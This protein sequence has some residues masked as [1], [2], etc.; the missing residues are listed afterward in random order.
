MSIVDPQDKQK[1]VKKAVAAW[2][3]IDPEKA[4]LATGNYARD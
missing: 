2:E 4:N 3:R 1:A